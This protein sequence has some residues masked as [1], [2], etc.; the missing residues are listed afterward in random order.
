MIQKLRKILGLEN[1][2]E[3][4]RD[5]ASTIEQESLLKAEVDLMSKEYL[6]TAQGLSQWLESESD[7]ETRELVKS[8]QDGLTSRYLTAL[9]E[10]KA[11][12]TAI[13]KAKK[14]FEKAH[15]HFEKALF[16]LKKNDLVQKILSSYRENQ[17]SLNEADTIIRS[18]TKEKVKYADNIVLNDK[19]E[20]L[21]VQ[22]APGGEGAN[23]WT[24]PGGH[25]EMGEDY[26]TA[27]K[28]ELKE[29]TGYEVGDCHKVSEYDN[30]DC[31][32]EYFLS[33]IDTAEQSPL[34]DA[35]ETRYTQFVPVKSLY[36]FPTLHTNMWDNVFQ[37]FGIQDSF[38]RI[39]KAIASGVVTNQKAEFEI[40]KAIDDAVGSGK[41]KKK[42]KFDKV[43]KEWKAGTLKS[44][45]GDKV[46]DQKQAI[47]I[48]LSE[49][50]QSISKGESLKGGDADGKSLEQIAKKHGVKVSKIASEYEIGLEEEKEHSEDEEERC[51]I[52]KDHLWK[53][54]NYYSKL[55]TIEKSFTAEFEKAKSLG[56]LVP[57]KVQIK[58]KD[59]RIHMAIRWVDPSTGQSPKVIEGLKEEKR[60]I[61]PTEATLEDSVAALVASDL[62]KADKVRNL[63]DLG[64][65][66]TKLLILLTGE[67]YP[68]RY[69]TQS[70]IDIKSLPDN[71]EVILK[72]VR[73]EQ[74]NN[75]TPEARE[76]NKFLHRDAGQIEE[77]WDNFR[78]DLDLVIDG[79]AGAK[80]AVG[81]G[82]GGVGK[83]YEVTRLLKKKEYRKYNAEI[84]PN[85]DQYDYKVIKGRISPVQVYAEMYR[86]RDKLLVFDDCDS[87]LILPEVQGFLKTGLDTGEDTTISN[88]TG[89]K[90][91]NI[92]GD[93]DSGEI[94]DEFSFK[95]RVIVVTNLTAK[96]IDQAVKSRALIS[97][98]TMTVDETIQK[99]ST[100]KN[101][102]EILSADKSTIVEVSQEARD[103]AFE[104]LKENKDKLGSDINTRTYYNAVILAERG[105][106]QGSDR[107]KI[108]RRVVG[109]F[110]SVTGEFDES[111]RQQKK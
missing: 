102:I 27:A 42:K 21:I 60:V 43:M 61:E 46:T 55:K 74:A 85:Q 23:T 88:L 20:I 68:G 108:R 1:Y 25:V 58:S 95:G 77:L 81:Y 29:E 96:D 83:T 44:G 14:Y 105:L 103:F 6:K 24:L 101:D 87:F 7:K 110:D 8:Q 3:S 75:D 37:I 76:T 57:K 94:P 59:G 17:M 28:R 54:P 89:R 16:D 22:R 79:V 52:A 92:E 13:E 26:C 53:D 15:P 67:V 66:D 35:E 56:H 86:H 51:E 98:L 73:K 90:V 5:F 38:T 84:Q 65:Y 111:I 80:F 107:D 49:S 11:Q 39:K 2:E 82:T 45:S 78:D 70:D 30:D 50:G 36:S 18:A 104:I 91:Y 33:M 93:K 41:D 106:Q 97:N 32:I 99:L 12:F 34:V 63:I 72:E 69:F 9:S 62:P 71:S 4:L 47:A 100:I 31:H 109:F 10:R 64:I 40:N 48:A 19:G